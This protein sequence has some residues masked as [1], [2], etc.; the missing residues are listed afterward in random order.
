MTLLNKH[1]MGSHQKTWIQSREQMECDFRPPTLDW[2]GLCPH[3]RIRFSPCI[4]WPSSQWRV[5]MFNHC[6]HC[7][8]KISAHINGGLALVSNKPTLYVQGDVTQWEGVGLVETDFSEKTFLRRN[9]AV[10]PVWPSPPSKPPLHR[11]VYRQW[12]Q[13]IK[14]GPKLH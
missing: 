3:G 5:K 2:L 14:W 7:I 9:L 4:R 11:E 8:E 1:L 12:N 13:L 6:F 10:W